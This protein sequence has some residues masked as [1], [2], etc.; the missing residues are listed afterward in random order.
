MKRAW[1][2]ICKDVSSGYSIDLYIIGIVIINNDKGQ[3]EN[4]KFIPWKY[5]PF[6]NGLLG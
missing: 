4:I 6:S 3:N 2:E 1:I 5:K